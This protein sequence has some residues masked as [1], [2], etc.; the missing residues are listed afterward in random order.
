MYNKIIQKYGDEM[1]ELECIP[2]KWGNSL[3]IAIPKRVAEDEGV[4]PNRKIRVLILGER[5]LGEIFGAL[6]DWKKTTEKIVE[7]IDSGWGEH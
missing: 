2:K 5:K 3:G 4:K 6:K 1:I 7:E